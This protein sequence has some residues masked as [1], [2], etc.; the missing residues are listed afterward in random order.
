MAGQ[1]NQATAGCECGEVHRRIVE[2]WGAGR[3][4]EAVTLIA[5]DA[6]DHRGGTSG[7]HTWPNA[8]QRQVGAHA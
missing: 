4:A 8:W 2:L 6:I 3:L 5:P 7:D 1:S